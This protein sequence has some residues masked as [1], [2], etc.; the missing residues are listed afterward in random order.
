M[1]LD[2]PWRPCKAMTVPLICTGAA[3]LLH[4]S[5]SGVTVPAATLAEAVSIAVTGCKGRA[6]CILQP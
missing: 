2:A 6:S 3:A 1:E 4:V 5:Y